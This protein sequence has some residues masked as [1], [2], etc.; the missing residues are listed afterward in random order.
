MREQNEPR[1]ISITGKTLAGLA[2]QVFKDGP[3][4]YR[5]Y[6]K[7]GELGD[8]TIVSISVF[9]ENTPPHVG[10]TS[11]D[12]CHRDPIKVPIESSSHVALELQGNAA[13]RRARVK[14]DGDLVDEGVNLVAFK[15]VGR[16]GQVDG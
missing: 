5:I 1:K 10:V 7:T 16:V 9:I 6:V 15:A 11:S 8:E 2:G 12:I 13:E 4:E 14:L 3:Y